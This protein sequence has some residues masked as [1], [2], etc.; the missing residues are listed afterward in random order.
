MVWKRHPRDTLVSRIL[1]VAVVLSALAALAAPAA[2]AG[3][4]MWVGYHDDPSYRW[5]PDRM[6][7][8]ERSADDGATRS[9]GIPYAKQATYVRQSMAIAG[10]CRLSGCSS[11]PASRLTPMS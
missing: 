7:R 4:R 2:L 1:R 9:L 11:R 8:I 5:V 10:G 6:T 3:E